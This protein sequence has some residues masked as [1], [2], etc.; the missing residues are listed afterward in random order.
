MQLHVITY[1]WGAI[2][3]LCHLVIWSTFYLKPDPAKSHTDPIGSYSVSYNYL[4]DN[5]VG[6]DLAVFPL[7]KEQRVTELKGKLHKQHTNGNNIRHPC[8]RYINWLYQI[9]LTQQ[10]VV[11]LKQYLFYINEL[12][13]LFHSKR[14][15]ENE[16]A[17][18]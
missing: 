7:T 14:C 4:V 3:A 18:V 13:V 2:V 12:Y 16:R 5:H 9:A 8:C 17:T 10:H 11:H 1:F 6:A 15:Q